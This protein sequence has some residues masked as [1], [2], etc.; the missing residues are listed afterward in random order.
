VSAAAYT[1]SFAGT[2]ATML[3]DIDGASST[4]ALQNPPND[5]TLSN[6]GALGVTV[7]GDGGMDIAGGANGLVLAAL[8][9]SAAGPSSLYRID[10]ATGAATLVN[11]AAMPAASAVGSGAVGLI[12][13]A[14]AIR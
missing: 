12:D 10:L 2:T 14:I 9:T 8:R 7:A 11:G 4:L 5:G 13:I 6:I 3:F 1:N